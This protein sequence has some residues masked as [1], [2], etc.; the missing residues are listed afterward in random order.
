[1]KFL[2]LLLATAF[3]GCHSKQPDKKIIK[4]T[5]AANKNADCGYEKKTVRCKSLFSTYN[6]SKKMTAYNQLQTYFA[7]SLLPCWYGTA[8]DYNGT[9][10]SPVEGKI[11]CGY[12]ITTTLRQSGMQIN[13]IKLAQCPSSELIRSVCTGI[14]IYSNKP[15]EEMIS[16][17]KKDGTG[18]YIAG[19][20]FH[21]GFVWYDGN[22]VYFIHASFY[23]SKCVIREKAVNCAV[24]KNSQLKMIGKVNFMQ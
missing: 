14:K 8:W 22:D 5:I 12:F 11:A 21:T 19:L 17:V 4:S 13:R 16:Q 15:V 24:L 2:L 10:L 3:T 9:T 18:L 20:D 6:Q 7:D 23:G 1:M